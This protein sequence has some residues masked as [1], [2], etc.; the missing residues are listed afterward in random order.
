M[1]WFLG[2]L[3]QDTEATADCL[4]QLHSSFPNGVNEWVNERTRKTQNVQKALY[5]CRTLIR[6]GRS[7]PVLRTW[8]F[9][10]WSGIYR[11]LRNCL[12]VQCGTQHQ[13]KQHTD[14]VSPSE[15]TAFWLTL[16][17]ITVV[18][19]LSVWLV[20][21]LTS[22]YHQL[23]SITSV[24]IITFVSLKLFHPC[25]NTQ[26]TVTAHRQISPQPSVTTGIQ[27]TTVRLTCLFFPSRLCQAHPTLRTIDMFTFRGPSFVGDRLLLRA[28]V[29]NAFK[30][31]YECFQG[32]WG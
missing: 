23:F 27:G 11:L 7:S 9:S 10:G 17:F 24:F 5:R 28:I 13:T 2:F 32:L 21:F 26:V 19:V 22:D 15:Q 16:T 18:T 4:G 12:H 20:C 29:N 25:M 30:N 31:R 8:T 1:V 3:E 6:L 14:D